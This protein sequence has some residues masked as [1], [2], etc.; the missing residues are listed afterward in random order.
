MDD[1][2]AQRA[3]V[4]LQGAEEGLRCL[5]VWKCIYR[6]HIPHQ[7]EDLEA[8]ARSDEEGNVVEPDFAARQGKR[9]D[10]SKWCEVGSPGQQEV[11]VQRDA[12]QAEGGHIWG[13]V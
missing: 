7:L 12:I 6:R 8:I 11:V 2:D 1:E 5:R 13:V 4:F 3:R 10:R 9:R